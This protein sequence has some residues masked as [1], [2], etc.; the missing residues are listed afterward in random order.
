MKTIINRVDPDKYQI[1]IS[2]VGSLDECVFLDIETT[3]LSSEHSFIYLIGVA[4]YNS[5]ESCYEIKQW[6]IQNASEEEAMLKEAM[7]F[8]GQYNTLV[9]YN[10]NSS[11]IQ[12]QLYQFIF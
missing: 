11:T 7:D 6:L 3:G 10:G 1:D 4:Y 9:H 5:D 8:I 12:A 2:K